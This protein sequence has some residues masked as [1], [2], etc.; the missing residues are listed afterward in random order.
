LARTVGG[1]ALSIR[2]SDTRETAT[3]TTDVPLVIRG[4]GGEGI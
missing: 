2:Y 3:L 1:V 4:G